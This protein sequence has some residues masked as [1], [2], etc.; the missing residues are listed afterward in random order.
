MLPTAKPDLFNMAENIVKV[1][2]IH[3]NRSMKSMFFKC[4]SFTT[5]N[6]LETRIC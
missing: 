1:F 2:S 3:Q 5:K 4:N 6:V